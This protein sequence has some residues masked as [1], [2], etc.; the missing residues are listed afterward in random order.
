MTNLSVEIIKNKIIEYLEKEL[1]K[2]SN[3][4]E[5]LEKLSYQEIFKSVFLGQQKIDKTD[6]KNFDKAINEL[7]KND[8]ILKE[9]VREIVYFL[10]K[11]YDI[12]IGYPVIKWV[13]PLTAA[14]AFIMFASFFNKFEYYVA[15]VV[16]LYAYLFSNIILS[17]L[18]WAKKQVL[19][20]RKDTILSLKKSLGDHKIRIG[21]VA[22]LSILFTIFVYVKI[23]PLT[24]ITITV[25]LG[26][27]PAIWIM[28]GSIE[29]KM[30]KSKK[31][32]TMAATTTTS[33]T[34]TTTAPSKE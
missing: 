28:I 2:N 25:F 7:K 11:D 17:V 13:L 27:L 5:I 26:S 20:E 34:T 31:T 16:F 9:E 3:K 24:Q 29:D 18:G 22:A 19:E 30:E 4:G 15:W 1:S 6:I 23:I 8:E 33:T 12:Q 14:I 21:L 32:E 10:L